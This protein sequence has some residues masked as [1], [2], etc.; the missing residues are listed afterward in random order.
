MIAA[1]ALSSTNHRYRCRWCC[2]GVSK[3]NCHRAEAMV[4]T[5]MPPNKSHDIRT[6]PSARR[7]KIKIEIRC[8]TKCFMQI[9][10]SHARNGQHLLCDRC[11]ICFSKCVESSVAVHSR[12]GWHTHD[13]LGSIGLAPLRNDKRFSIRRAAD[14]E[15]KDQK[16]FGCDRSQ[17]P[18][19]SIRLW[20]SGCGFY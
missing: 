2:F 6:I 13:V 1:I 14:T 16:T 10:F 4:E 8:T 11:Q 18:C 7:P 9:H 17:N 20:T 5:L 3:F 12:I 15:T 19:P